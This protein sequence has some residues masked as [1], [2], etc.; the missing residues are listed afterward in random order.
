[1]NIHVFSQDLAAVFESF[2]GPSSSYTITTPCFTNKTILLNLLHVAHSDL[3]ASDVRNHFPVFY[4]PVQSLS[5]L[6]SWATG[7]QTQLVCNIVVLNYDR[8]QLGQSQC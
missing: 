5:I 3:P 2:F 4:T 8:V 6:H 1:M 7:N